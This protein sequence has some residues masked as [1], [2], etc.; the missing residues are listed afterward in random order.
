MKDFRKLKVW[1]ESHELTLDVLR[2]IDNER[3][4]AKCQ[5]PR[6]ALNADPR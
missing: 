1:E 6:A 4:L 3:W 5:L 2:K